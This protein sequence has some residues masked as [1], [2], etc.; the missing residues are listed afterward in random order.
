MFGH[1]SSWH[2]VDRRFAHGKDQPRA[3]HGAYTVARDEVHARVSEQAHATVEQCAMGDIRVIT[4]IL[5]GARFCTAFM[6]AAELQA[7]L[8]HF[9][10][11]QGDLHGIVFDAGQQQPRR[12]QTGGGGAAAGGQAA[13]QRGR[14]FLGLVTHLR[15]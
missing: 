8:H 6:Q 15:A 5:E 14:L 7:H 4:G 9:A 10:L 11:G 13:A 1:H 2:R 3:G 12:R